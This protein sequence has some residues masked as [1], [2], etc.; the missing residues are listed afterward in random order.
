MPLC[1]VRP[2]TWYDVVVFGT[3][4]DLIRCHCV[5]YDYRLDTMSLC[6]VRLSTWY[7]VI[8]FGTTIDLIRC[9]CVWYDYR[10]DTMS[11]FG[12]PIDLW[13]HVVE[14]GATVDH[15]YLILTKVS[16]HHEPFQVIIR[17][18]T[19]HNNT[20]KHRCVFFK[21]CHLLSLYMLM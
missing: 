1:L 8:M 15:N 11:L 12:G 10:L 2:S 20:V 21:L 14:L 19:V 13:Y 17:I 6:F 9:H 4:I 5:W 7:D 16:S 3:T 18:D